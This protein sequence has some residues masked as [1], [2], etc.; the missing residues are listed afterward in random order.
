MY[1]NVSIK[2][3]RGTRQTD[4]TFLQLQIFS[5]YILYSIWY[6]LD[7]YYIMFQ[8]KGVYRD[9][10]LKF[11]LSKIILIYQSEKD[12]TNVKKVF[13]MVLKN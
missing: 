6:I 11:V 3:D 13:T 1:N 4:D 5:M 2:Y 7:H 8:S 12:R 9:L 10:I